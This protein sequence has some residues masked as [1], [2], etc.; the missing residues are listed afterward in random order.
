VLNLMIHIK[1]F[2]G[3]LQYLSAAH[4]NGA[5]YLLCVEHASLLVPARAEVGRISTHLHV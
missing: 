4:A 2:L 1:V 3:Q 5:S